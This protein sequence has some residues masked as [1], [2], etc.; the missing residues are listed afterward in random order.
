MLFLSDG[1]LTYRSEPEAAEQCVFPLWGPT[2]CCGMLLLEQGYRRVMMMII[3]ATII[4]IIVILSEIT[5]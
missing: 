4:I 2:A 5:E 3:I 1:C